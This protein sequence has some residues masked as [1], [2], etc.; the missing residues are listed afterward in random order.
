MFSGIPA[1]RWRSVHPVG[2]F[3]ESKTRRSDMRL[4]SIPWFGCVLALSAGIL[5]AGEAGTVPVPPAS[6]PAAPGANTITIDNF[7]FTP[8]VLTVTAGARVTWVNKDD[9]PHTATSTTKPRTIDSG[10]LDTDESYSVTFKQPGTYPYFCTV[11]P[12]MTGTIIVK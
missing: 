3:K 5:C 7:A 4:S 12:H 11:H 9:V 2:E 1:A 6:Q 10:T 8:R